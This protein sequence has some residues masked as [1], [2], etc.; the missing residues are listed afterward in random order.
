[1]SNEEVSREDYNNLIYLTLA[2]MVNLINSEENAE[3]SK[4]ERNTKNDEN[5]TI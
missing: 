3:D 1:M 5:A 2:L 4:N